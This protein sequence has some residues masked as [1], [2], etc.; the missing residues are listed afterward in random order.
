MLMITS[1]IEKLSKAELVKTIHDLKKAYAELEKS[2]KNKSA[3]IGELTK[4]RIKTSRLEGY[5]DR[6]L[7]TDAI[8]QHVQHEDKSIDVIKV[9]PNGPDTGLRPNPLV[10]TKDRIP[11]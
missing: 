2:Y 1:D 8:I 10:Y 3:L 9:R 7:D 4:Y 6:I 11:F 5:I